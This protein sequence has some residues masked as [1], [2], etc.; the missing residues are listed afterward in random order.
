MENL[1]YGLGAFA[2]ASD[3]WSAY[4]KGLDNVT[5]KTKQLNAHS[6]IETTDGERILSFGGLEDDGS[7]IDFVGED[8]VNDADYFNKKLM[9]TTEYY[10]SLDKVAAPK[11]VMSTNVRGV[12]MDA[13]T[14][15]VGKMAEKFQ[16]RLGFTGPFSKSFHCAVAASKA[17]N[18]SGVFNIP[19]FRMPGL[20][21]LQMSIRDY[22][23]MSYTLNY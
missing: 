11:F 17:L 14:T 1:G 15:Y 18:H 23:F 9:S 16:Y 3:V 12:N 13:M 22:T 21:N 19:I 20:L 4:Y 2:N 8:A 5:L 7:Y 10:P 6:Q